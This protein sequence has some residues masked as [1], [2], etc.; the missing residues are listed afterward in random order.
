M[1]EWVDSGGIVATFPEGQFSWDGEPS[2]IIAGLDQLIKYLNVP[3]VC[4]N[5]DNG[6]YVKPAWAK[7]SRKAS[8]KITINKPIDVCDVTIENIKNL[9]FSNKESIA[10]KVTHRENLIYGL[11]NTI[12]YCPSCNKDQ[13]LVESRNELAC[14]LCDDS[15]IISSTNIIKQ[16]N[17]KRSMNMKEFFT[18]IKEVIDLNFDKHDLISSLAEV[19]LSNISKAKPELLERGTLRIDKNSVYVGDKE[20]KLSDIQAFTLD[21]GDLILFRTQFDRYSLHLPVDSR[22]VFCHILSRSIN[23]NP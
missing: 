3:V 15:W 20:F 10:K 11:A 14:K 17:S 6:Q 4:V 19:S 9:I 12:R 5:L 8:I 23:A 16:N 22:F 2:G 21:W 1:K 13:S 18:K 7:N